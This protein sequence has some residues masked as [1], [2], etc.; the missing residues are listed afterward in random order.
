[1]LN[2]REDV[3]DEALSRIRQA[4][5]AGIAPVMVLLPN[6]LLVTPFAKQLSQLFGVRAPVR[7]T[8]LAFWAEEQP[9]QGRVVPQ[10][11][12]LSLVYDALKARK[13]FE[14]QDRWALARETLS[15]VDELTHWGFSL[16][17]NPEDFAD[18]LAQAY[19]ARQ[20]EP[21]QFEARFV[22]DLWLVLNQD[23]LELSPAMA[24]QQRLAALAAGPKPGLCLVV[25]P[26]PLTPAE[27]HCLTALGAQTIVGP[28]LGVRPPM[29]SDPKR[30]GANL[31]SA[32]KVAKARTLHAAWQGPE[33]GTLALRAQIIKEQYPNSP[34]QQQV[35]LKGF[36]SME[37]EA[38]HG[39]NL[40]QG[41]LGEQRGAV[42][43]VAQDRVVARR[44]RAMLERRG[45]A[46]RD[47][48]GW[49]FSTTAASTV[50]MRWLNMI[51]QDGH[52]RLLQDLLH[53]VH[54]CADWP[55]EKRAHASM[56]LE[57][58][59]RRANWVSGFKE[60]VRIAQHARDAD[61]E[62][63]AAALEL[64]QRFQDEASRFSHQRQRFV[65]WMAHLKDSLNGF[66]ILESLQQDAAGVQLLE[67]LEQ[68]TLDAEHA[69]G[70]LTF[71]EWMRALDHQ[72]EEATFM[73]NEDDG[74]V[75]ITQLSMTRLRSFDAV[76]MV[77]ADR[78]HLPFLKTTS[79]FGDAVRASLGL[80][81]R[82]D[83]L[84]LMHRD[85]A[86][87][88]ARTPTACITWR[89]EN[90]GERNPL[91]AP[92]QRLDVFHQ[93]AWGKSLMATPA[94]LADAPQPHPIH[95]SVMPAP[96]LPATRVPEAVSASGYGR[97]MACPY[98]FFADTVLGLGNEDAVSETVG[99]RDYGQWVHATLHR[100][101]SKNASV[102]ALG[103][104]AAIEQL[105]QH[106]RRVFEG[107]DSPDEE[108]RAW[109]LRWETRIP[110]VIDWM[111][112]WEGRGWR[113]TEGEI[114]RDVLLGEHTEGQVKLKGTLDRVDRRI[115]PENGEAELA[116]LDYKLKNARAIRRADMAAGEDVQLSVY[117]L[118]MQEPVDH[119]AYLTLDGDTPEQV[120]CDDPNELALKVGE[121]LVAVIKDLREGA[122]LPAHGDENAC[123]LCRFGGL[124]RHDH[125]QGA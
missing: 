46:V 42:A 47:E 31:G 80:P 87:L 53:S 100:F 90:A 51:H 70:H 96:I 95:P 91:A 6:P 32:L 7:A 78:E 81:T 110:A 24:Y 64:A 16:P 52:Y 33:H 118:L 88:L 104:T 43:L 122:A 22:H 55:V 12:R 38:L 101:H 41:W 93:L 125:W 35:V 61:T 40:I 21:L 18:H 124:C 111:L 99:K 71:S 114:R 115:N 63:V 121:R 123:G 74:A 112:Q 86:E 79:F 27:Q 97:L 65:E 56:T 116:I 120:R 62:G 117:T 60:L 9:L 44:L 28:A 94:L 3:L 57:R 2:A 72:F 15:L 13:W 36:C 11:E 4:V 54:L 89:N 69:V 92:L 19:A 85:L 8:T 106:S 30:E 48:S 23:P 29:G 34:L 59:V 5:S 109:R 82:Q 113:Y 103:R 45:I 17:V 83:Q 26:N 107:Q 73:E 14:L 1:M 10:L 68:L 66:G 50:V 98:Q 105:L 108:W 20:S 102:L 37:D 58:L 77:G 49:T 25:A 75:R 84:A 76:L 39:A 67:I 119:A